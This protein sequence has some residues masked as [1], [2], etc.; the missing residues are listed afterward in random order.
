MNLSRADLFEEILH[1]YKSQ[2][3]QGLIDIQQACE[4]VRHVSRMIP[5]GGR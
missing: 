2:V 1:Y 4:L 3:D 5:A